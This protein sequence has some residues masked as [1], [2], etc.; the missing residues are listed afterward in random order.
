MR[1]KK[2]EKKKSD[3]VINSDLEI[4]INVLFNVDEI[5]RS[6]NPA[7]RKIMNN[8][9]KIELYDIYEKIAFY[10]K[11]IS[12]TCKDSSCIKTIAYPIEDLLN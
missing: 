2:T 7:I 6:L 3:V 5:L 12:E 10:F 9:Q 8:D 4:I 1:I 11:N